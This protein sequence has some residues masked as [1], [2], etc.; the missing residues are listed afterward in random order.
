MMRSLVL[1]VC[2]ATS[3]WAAHA[4]ERPPLPDG[5]EYVF[6]ESEAVDLI[7]LA[8]TTCDPDE[9]DFKL[10]DLELTVADA[11]P[12]GVRS[13]G[14]LGAYVERVR[15]AGHACEIE[16]YEWGAT[17]LCSRSGVQPAGDGGRIVLEIEL[18]PSRHPELAHVAEIRVG[19]TRVPGRWAWA[20]PGGAR[21]RGRRDNP[22]SGARAK[23]LP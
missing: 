9:P 10:E 11:G 1:A 6:T 19:E 5:C 18:Q 21:Q 20:V 16:P 12:D 17:V 3:A 13:L 8:R 14:P 2:V 15:V 7:D 23:P 22:I 4:D